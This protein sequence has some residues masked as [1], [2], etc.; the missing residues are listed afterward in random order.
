MKLQSKSFNHQS[1]IPSIYAYDRNN[2]SPELNWEAVPHGTQSFVIIVE[3]PDASRKTFIHWVIYNIPP[4]LNHLPENIP[5]I[6]EF[7]NG[8]KQAR[9]DYGNTGYD[10]PCPPDGVHRY[11]FKLYALKSILNIEKEATAQQVKNAMRSF[12]I[13]SAELLGRY[14]KY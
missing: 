5:K 4:D 3:D 6:H 9:N 1:I 14:G 8:I 12:I 7:E 13:D 10:G 11:Y 2:I